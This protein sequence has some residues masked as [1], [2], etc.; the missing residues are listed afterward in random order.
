MTL[1]FR[2]GTFVGLLGSL[3]L[4]L[5]TPAQT[6]LAASFLAYVALRLGDLFHGVLAALGTPQVMILSLVVAIAAGLYGLAHA[7]R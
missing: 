5:G 6:V 7:K 1:A 2:V 4:T 3:L